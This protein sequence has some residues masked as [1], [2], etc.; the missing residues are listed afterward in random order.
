MSLIPN[1]S[2]GNSVVTKANASFSV[3]VNIGT[4]S[5]G[6]PTTFTSD[7]ID[8]GGMS[9]IAIQSQGTSNGL[10]PD[11]TVGSA[12]ITV[13]VSSGTFPAFII[14][15]ALG[16]FRLDRFLAPLTENDNTYTSSEIFRNYVNPSFKFMR[17]S[18]D[19][20]DIGSLVGNQYI[21]T[22]INL[23]ATA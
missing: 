18:V 7:W 20:T 8:I 5:T 19:F 14:S 11:S 1:N 3:G 22:Y 17:V 23:T 13:E 15:N 9:N 16:A 4:A 6:F 21:K 2:L 10:T 12:L